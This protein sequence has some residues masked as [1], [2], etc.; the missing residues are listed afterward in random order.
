MSVTWPLFSS[1]INNM[2]FVLFCSCLIKSG[3]S[4]LQN[5]TISLLKD[6]TAEISIWVLV[7]IPENTNTK[8]GKERQGEV[9]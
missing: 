4:R 1:G 8:Q 2:G 7:I 3:H 9:V 6:V 5:D